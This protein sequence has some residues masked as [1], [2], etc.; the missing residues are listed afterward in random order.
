M[1]NKKCKKVDESSDEEEWPC[2]GVWRTIQLQ[3]AIICLG[4]IPRMQ[5]FG[6][7]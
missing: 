1:F 5:E 4:S 7:Q 3:S 6:T 2:F